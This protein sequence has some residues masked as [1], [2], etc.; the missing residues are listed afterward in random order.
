MRIYN[1]GRKYNPYLIAL[2][3]K[4]PYEPL[5]DE[6]LRELLRIVTKELGDVRIMVWRSKLWSDRGDMD[7]VRFRLGLA[8]NLGLGN[9]APVM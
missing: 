1:S 3:D 4:W 7:N 6:L 2:A 9:L 8:D 5:A